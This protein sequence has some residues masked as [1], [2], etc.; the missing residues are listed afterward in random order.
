M[1][2]RMWLPFRV[3]GAG[4]IIAHAA[5]DV[6]ECCIGRFCDDR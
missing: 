5:D 6:I 4:S 3:I 1:T 2:R